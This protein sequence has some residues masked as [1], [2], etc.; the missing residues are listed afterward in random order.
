[1]DY[2][3]FALVVGGICLLAWVVVLGHLGSL[4][5]EGATL[6]KRIRAA[7]FALLWIAVLLIVERPLGVYAGEGLVIGTLLTLLGAFGYLTG[8]YI[9]PIG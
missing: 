4:V 1:M 9:K 3:A 7:W 2:E 6:K 8:R 5:R